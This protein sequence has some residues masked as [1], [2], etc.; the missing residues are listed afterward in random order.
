LIHLADEAGWVA[1]D[2]ATAQ[3]VKFPNVFS[4]GDASSMPNSKTAAAI[5]SQAP[6]TV[7]NLRAVMDGKPLVPGYGAVVSRHFFLAHSELEG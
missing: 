4:L 1:V 3:H 2:Q 6:V 7:F 5:S